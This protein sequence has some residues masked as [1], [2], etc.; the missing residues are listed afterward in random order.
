MTFDNPESFNFANTSWG[1]K[2][3][4]LW[5]RTVSRAN[6]SPISQQH[7]LS[8]FLWCW[9]A[10]HGS[11]P[12]VT[13]WPLIVVSISYFTPASNSPAA[14]TSAHV[15]SSLTD[16]APA[17][18]HCIG[19]PFTAVQH[20]GAHPGYLWVTLVWLLK[21]LLLPKKLKPTKGLGCG[22]YM[23]EKVQLWIGSILWQISELAWAAT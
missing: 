11:N 19:K 10:S 1:S 3:V 15:F 23:P 2:A 4:L 22:Q 6:V 5:F 18:L 7:N 13:H 21:L 9:C 14:G 17:Y 8:Y 20:Q 12:L 16:K